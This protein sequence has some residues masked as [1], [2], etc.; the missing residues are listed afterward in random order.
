[1]HYSCNRSRCVD[2]IHTKRHTYVE[3]TAA[4]A[5]ATNVVTNIW[6]TIGDPAIGGLETVR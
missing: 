6:C 4:V 3:F 2:N 5:A 1:M